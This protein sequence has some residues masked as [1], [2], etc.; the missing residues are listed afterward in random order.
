MNRLTAL[1]TELLHKVSVAHTNTSVA[2]NAERF[3]RFLLRYK[4][5]IYDMYIE[6]FEFPDDSANI[7]DMFRELLYAYGKDIDEKLEEI[8]K[9]VV[10]MIVNQALCEGSGSSINERDCKFTINHPDGINQNC[11]LYFYYNS[12]KKGFSYIAFAIW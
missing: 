6:R 9:S 10:H 4:L 8:S 3:F 5:G 11:S 7:Y 12:K 2:I 1:N